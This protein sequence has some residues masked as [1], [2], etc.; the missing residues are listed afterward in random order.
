[1]ARMCCHTAGFIWVLLKLQEA[2]CKDLFFVV[3]GYSSGDYTVHVM[4]YSWAVVSLVIM[5]VSHILDKMKI[6][7]KS[8]V[9]G[10]L[11]ALILCRNLEFLI[12]I[13]RYAVL[14][15]PV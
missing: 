7:N 3:F 1:M 8:L 4:L 11:S 15:F 13:Y 12:E 5:A 2:L 14:R 10:I 9:W 6:K